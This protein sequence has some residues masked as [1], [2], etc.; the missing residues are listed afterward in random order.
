MSGLLLNPSRAHSHL[1]HLHSKT[2]YKKRFCVLAHN[3][4]LY[5]D[6]AEPHGTPLGIFALD[7]CRIEKAAEIVKKGFK[8]VKTNLVS[9]GCFAVGVVVSLG[10]FRCRVLTTTT[11]ADSLHALLLVW[12]RQPAYV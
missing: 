3:F 10:V 12:A 6:K 1:N 5:F 7:F 11:T 2:S 4:L 8:E 9:E